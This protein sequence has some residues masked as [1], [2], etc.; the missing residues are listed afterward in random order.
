MTLKQPN[1][2]NNYTNRVLLWNSINLVDIA[3]MPNS[4]ECSSTR[5][6]ELLTYTCYVKL[7]AVYS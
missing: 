7:L 1:I 3:N 5:D 4:V 6:Y 2:Y